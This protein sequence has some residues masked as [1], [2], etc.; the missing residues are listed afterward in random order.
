IRKEYKEGSDSMDNPFVRL[1]PYGVAP[2][3]ALAMFETDE[4]VKLTVTV[5]GKEDRGDISRTYDNYKTKHAI[6][7]LGLYPDY[8]NTIT[9]EVTTVDWETVTSTLT[10]K[11]DPLH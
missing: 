4:P 7:V 9:I 11:T 5:E 6:P 3:T 10:N 8:E 1:D 2:L